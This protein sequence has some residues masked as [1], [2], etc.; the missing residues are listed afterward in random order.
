MKK[1]FAIIMT[2]CLLSSAFSM[3]AFAA[4]AP[5]ADVKALHSLKLHRRAHK[6]C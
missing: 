1:L 3:M 5:A 2:I 6:A 4:E